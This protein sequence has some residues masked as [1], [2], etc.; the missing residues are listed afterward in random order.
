VVAEVLLDQVPLL[1]LEELQVLVVVEL[2]ENTQVLKEVPEQ[3]TLVVEAAVAHAV[4]DQEMLADQA[5]LLF[6]IPVLKEQPEEQFHVSHVRHN[7]YLIAQ[8]RLKR[9]TQL[10]LLV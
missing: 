8:P 3:L 7:I 1:L 9:L 2:V 4:P 5:F 6:N 10:Q